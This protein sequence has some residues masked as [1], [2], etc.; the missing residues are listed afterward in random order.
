[1]ERERRMG[2]WDYLVRG[3]SSRSRAAQGKKKFNSWAMAWGWVL[4]GAGSK[5]ETKANVGLC[6]CQMYMSP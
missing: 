6:S 4:G 2:S 1:M 3:A 5:Q